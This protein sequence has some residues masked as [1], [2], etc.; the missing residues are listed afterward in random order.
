MWVYVT[1]GRMATIVAKHLSGQRARRLRAGRAAP[2]LAAFFIGVFSSARVPVRAQTLQGVYQRVLA[3]MRQPPATGVLV[4]SLQLPPAALKAGLR[5][6][7]I[8]TRVDGRPIPNAAALHQAIRAVAGNSHAVLRVRA[9]R[10]SRIIVLHLPPAALELS[11]L[12]VLAGAPA[13]LNPTATP[14]RRLNLHWNRAPTV[15]PQPGQILGHDMWLLVFDHD[16]ACGSLHITISRLGRRWTLHWNLAV[17]RGGPLVA[18]RWRIRFVTTRARAARPF[19]LEELQWR[20]PSRTVIARDQ[21]R[22]L[23]GKVTQDGRTQAFRHPSVPGAVPVPALVA[24]AAA[25]PRRAGVVL[26][27]AELSDRTLSTRLGCVLQSLGRVK[28]TIG[29]V[30]NRVWA[31]RALWLDIPQMTFFF[32][33]DGAL[34]K[35][36]WGAHRTAVKVASPGVVRQVFPGDSL[37]QIPAKTGQVASPPKR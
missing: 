4:I 28:T 11:V 29:G 16:L 31:V 25:M 23:A 36:K 8:L 24:V 6:A 19:R 13:P 33:K 30:K 35:I 32:S 22:E 17:L 26:P 21:G 1:A 3:V 5:P 14:R 10:G 7:D 9:V 12:P 15:Q 2:V 27:L 34:L 18:Q 37:E 20:Q